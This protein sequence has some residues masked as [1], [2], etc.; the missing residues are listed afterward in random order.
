MSKRETRPEVLMAKVM[1]E[2]IF[3]LVAKYSNAVGR[4]GPDSDQVR[5]IRAAHPKNA[6]FLEYADALDRIKRHLGGSGMEKQ[7]R[8][9]PATR[10]AS[11]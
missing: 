4:Y 7:S 6:E 10:A 3:Q 11:R 5:R 1:Q 2:T 8:R 9:P